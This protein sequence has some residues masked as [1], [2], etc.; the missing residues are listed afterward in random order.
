MT[1][2]HSVL[3]LSLLLMAAACSRDQSGGSKS[4]GE[5]SGDSAM[6]AMPGM[7]GASPGE[8]AASGSQPVSPPS[9]GEVALS[10]EQVRHGKIRWSPVASGLAPVMAVLPGQLMPNED[11]T[12][13]LGASAEGRVLAVHVR[14]G[15]RVTR[16]QV[17]VTLQSP[18]ASAAQAE[19][20]RARAE[21]SSR[22]AQ[23]TY[24]KAARD[25]A[26]RLLDLKAM[27]RQDYER[28]IADDELAQAAFRQAEAELVRA[29]T[30]A[31][32]LGAG[33]DPASASGEIALRAPLAGVVLARTA[34]PGAVVAAGA[35]LVVVTDVSSL[36]LTINAPEK[37]A[38]LFQRGRAL[39]FAVSA[40]PADTFTARID[41]VGAGLEPDTRTLLV[42][43]VTG[44]AS[45]RLKPEML[46]SVVVEGASNV[47]AVL[48]PDDA[49]QTLNGKSV[50]FIAMPDA[51]GGAHVMAREVVVG[52][53]SQGR[54][55]VIRGLA[56][57][58][59]VVTE[60]AIA[61]KAQLQK[62]SAPKMVM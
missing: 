57:G 43:A 31:E 55:A 2:K 21:V 3:V 61:V 46:A 34:V 20:A 17:L 12:A 18:A 29:V 15:D 50:V 1:N 40:F 4:T 7:G 33:V 52:S 41:A 48:V 32:Q 59:T 53:R 62:G 38:P 14:P 24:A 25:R 22:R 36:W 13:R 58:D 11:R 44:S 9:A 26:Q 42:R 45:G 10:A 51:A 28:A 54:A 49:V 39:R 30:T 56:P 5:L 16:G 35:P 8:R 60:G 23:A 19:I 6:K 47:R 37:L 27:P